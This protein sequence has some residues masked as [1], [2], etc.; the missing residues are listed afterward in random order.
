VHRELVFT[1]QELRRVRI[2]CQSCGTEVL[3]DL[4]K[5]QRVGERMAFTPRK[6]PSCKLDFDSTT[7]LLDV[8]QEHYAALA[9][10]GDRIAFCVT[11]PPEP[12]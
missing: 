8:I 10:M 2:T 12:S 6:C 1:I 3:L 9:G 11:D 4:A 5:F 7:R